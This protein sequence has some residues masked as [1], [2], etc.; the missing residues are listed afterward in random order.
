MSPE[1]YVRMCNKELSK[2]DFYCCVG[3]QDPSQSILD[4]IST[5]TDRYKII[6][7]PKEQEYLTQQPYKM[8][9]FYMLPKLHKS[10]YINDLLRNS[11]T[12][13]HIPNFNHDI[14]GRPIVGG[15][16]FHTSGLSEMLD[17]IL[18][19]ILQHIPHIVKDSFDLLQ[20]IPDEIDENT[21]LGTCDIKSLYTNITKDLAL[22]A[23]DYWVTKFENVIPLLRRFTKTFILHAPNYT[24][25]QLFSFQ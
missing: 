4:A 3:D 12:Y 15:P 11:S 22:K 8:A 7:T 10:E 9:Y 6:L 25:L 23:I 16:C 14:D 17:I 21:L 1:Y 18:K 19:P 5:F 2:Q 20:R 24:R 13:V